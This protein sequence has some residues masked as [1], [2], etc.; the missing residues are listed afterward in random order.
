MQASV[1]VIFEKKPGVDKSK[2]TSFLP[3]T[4]NAI[5]RITT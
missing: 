1:I 4:S 3:A 2:T 5:C